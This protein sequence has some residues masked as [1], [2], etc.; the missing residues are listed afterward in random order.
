MGAA[1]DL[2]FGAT[3]P[4]WSSIQDDRLVDVLARWGFA[5]GDGWLVPDPGHFEVRRP[6]RAGPGQAVA[7][8]WLRRASSAALRAT[9]AHR[10]APEGAL[11]DG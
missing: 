6:A 10:G 2:N 11:S 8:L 3:A 4:V 5:S 1:V 7:A 9:R